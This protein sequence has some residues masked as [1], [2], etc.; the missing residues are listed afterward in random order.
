M[1]RIGNEYRPSRE[2]RRDVVDRC[3]IW[4]LGLSGTVEYFCCVS[5]TF[6][7]LQVINFSNEQIGVNYCFTSLTNLRHCIHYFGSKR[8]LKKRISKGFQLIR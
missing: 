1:K 5:R 8:K 2:C 4:P 7:D 6:S 3:R